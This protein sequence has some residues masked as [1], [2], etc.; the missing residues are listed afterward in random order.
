MNPGR[1]FGKPAINRLSL[2]RGQLGP[3]QAFSYKWN[4]EST[5]PVKKILIL[6]TYT[7]HI[8]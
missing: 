3:Y 1:R 7:L 4:T 8:I 2:W 6:T 5:F